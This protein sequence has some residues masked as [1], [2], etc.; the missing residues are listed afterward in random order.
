MKL[1]GIQTTYVDIN[2]TG[3]Y[4]DLIDSIFMDIFK[5]SLK[6]ADDINITNDQIEFKVDEAVHGSPLYRTLK[7]IKKSDNEEL[8]YLANNLYLTYMDLLKISR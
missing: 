8:F 2:Y 1:S 6:A 5:I 7:I 4:A 3:S